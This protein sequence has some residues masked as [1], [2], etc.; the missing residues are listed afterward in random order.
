MLCLP[1]NRCFAPV[2][3]IL[4]RHWFRPIQSAD[5]TNQSSENVADIARQ[6]IAC[7]TEL[8]CIAVMRCRWR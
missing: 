6:L 8:A 7:F 3:D 1:S 5:L 2:T 4:Y